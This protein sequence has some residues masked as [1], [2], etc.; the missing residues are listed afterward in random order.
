M[1]WLE[2]KFGVPHRHIQPSGWEVQG[3]VLKRFYYLKNHGD[4]LRLFRFSFCMN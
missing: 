3:K 1:N 2:F 4:G